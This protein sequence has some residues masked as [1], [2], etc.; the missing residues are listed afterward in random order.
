MKLYLDIETIPTQLDW[1]IDSI[2]KSIEPPKSLKKIESINEWMEN[3]RESAIDAAY[4]KTALSGDFG[5]IVSIA[6]AFDDDDVQVKT[7]DLEKRGYKNCEYD[8]L[9]TFFYSLS[10]KK[11]TEIIGHNHV[12]FDL[13][14]IAKRCI[15][16]GIES[17]IKLQYKPWD[18][19]VYDTM[20]KWDAKN[21]VKQDTLAKILGID[22]KGDVD[23]SMVWDIV[24]AGDI[25]RLKQ[26]NKNDVETVRAIYKRMNFLD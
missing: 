13:P 20:T 12:G 7:F 9:K 15:V 8:V 22:G 19:G 6:W 10:G 26:Y 17:P 18:A 1:V 16:N 24:R 11:I 21:F 2:E 3:E 14:F 5:Q 25:E 23:G 4:R